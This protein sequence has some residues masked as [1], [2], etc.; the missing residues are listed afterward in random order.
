MNELQATASKLIFKMEHSYNILQPETNVHRNVEPESISHTR[1][2]YRHMERL[3]FPATHQTFSKLVA[4]FHKLFESVLEKFG[5]WYSTAYFVSM[6]PEILATNLEETRTG[7]SEIERDLNQKL[8]PAFRSCLEKFSTELTTYLSIKEL[9]SAAKDY[10]SVWTQTLEGSQF[11]QF[12]S[13]FTK[14]KQACAE[15]DAGLQNNVEMLDKSV[16]FV[17]HLM[18]RIERI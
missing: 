9:S 14:L 15:I 7:L 16:E 4:V 18:S 13:N 11:S 1:E 12:L 3:K 2:Y 8:I 5:E 17:T 10:K 6:Q